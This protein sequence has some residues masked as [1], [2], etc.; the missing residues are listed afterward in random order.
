MPERFARE[1]VV[2]HKADLDQSI[3]IL[4]VEGYGSVMETSESTNELLSTNTESLNNRGTKVWN[5]SV[6]GATVC[7]SYCCS[8]LGFASLSSNN[9]IRLLKHRLTTKYKLQQ[10]QQQVSVNAFQCNSCRSF[11]AKEMIRYAET[12]A[13]YTFVLIVTTTNHHHLSTCILLR[14]VSWDAIYANPFHNDNHNNKND[15]KELSFR[16]ALKI[17]FE[18]TQD[19]PMTNDGT[20]NN[21]FWGGVDL[22]CPPNKNTSSDSIPNISTTEKSSASS[23]RIY[24]SDDEF[25]EIRKEL[26]QNSKYSTTSVAQATICMKLGQS[27]SNAHLSFLTV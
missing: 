18:E 13:I 2:F 17:I 24:L 16:K 26:I 12:R 20:N 27:T 22:C 3:C 15:T 5:D 1:I 4:A 21:W 9:T 14:I 25:Q 8:V 23:V 11:I 6:G 7:C 10:Q 19:I